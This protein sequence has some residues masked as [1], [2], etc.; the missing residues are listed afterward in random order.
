MTINEYYEGSKKLYNVRFWYYKNGVKKSKYKQGF[1]RKKDAERWADSEEER[2]KGLSVGAD[3]T[4]VKD[5]LDRWISTK[6]DKLS[7]TTLRGYKVNIK[8]VNEYIGN[9]ILSKLKIIDI[10][11]MANSL[12]KKGLKFKSVSYILRTLHAAFQYAV[13][14]DLMQKNPCNGIEIRE[15]EKPFEASIYSSDDLSNLI[16]LLREQE[17]FIYPAVIL[18]SMRGLRRGECLGLPWSDVEF[19]KG[20][21]H[22]KNNYVIVDKKAYHKKVKTK[23]SDRKIDISGFIEEELRIIRDRNASKGIIK[24][25]VCEKDDGTLPDPTHLSRA[26]KNFQKANGLP[27]CRFH[28]LRHTH[29]MLQ[30]ECGTDLETLKRLLGHSKLAVTEKYLHENM[31]MKKAAS[32]K[33][34]KI[35]KFRCDNIVTNE[36]KSK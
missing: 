36:E 27:L 4:K 21:A 23:E 16:L 9:E 7:P 2:L 35:L 13:K 12:T 28:D 26:L 8:H 34:D 10:Q 5:F 6:E 18:G 17:H 3:K 15:D 19:E 25:F 11:E 30:L 22:V 29:A 31:N 32:S 1:E 33:L 20:I 14:N 24:T